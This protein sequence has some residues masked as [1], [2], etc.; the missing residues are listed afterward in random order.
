MYFS[1]VPSESRARLRVLQHWT[2]PPLAFWLPFQVSI[3]LYHF[4]SKPWQRGEEANQSTHDR[5]FPCSLP[6][7][8][9][10]VEMCHGTA[11]FQTTAFFYPVV[12]KK[13]KT[14]IFTIPAGIEQKHEMGSRLFPLKCRSSLVTW[15]SEAFFQREERIHSFHHSDLSRRWDTT[16]QFRSQQFQI[17]CEREEAWFRQVMFA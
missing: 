14:V 16:F 3:S 12:K 4:R 10:D 1:E 17:S 11:L 2:K 5:R 13:N 9:Q 15:L 6:Q 7:V 8:T